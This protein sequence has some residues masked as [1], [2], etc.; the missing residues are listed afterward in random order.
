MDDLT[1]EELFERMQDAI[2][3]FDIEGAS[4]YMDEVKRR[5]AAQRGAR[6]L[7]DEEDD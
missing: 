2:E 1:I 5:K 6:F 3:K 4:F 7:E